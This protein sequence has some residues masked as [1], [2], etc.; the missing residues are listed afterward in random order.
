MAPK[1][2]KENEILD[3]KEPSLS[4]DDDL[5][6]N[7]GINFFNLGH[8]WN[9]H[10]S[11]EEIW[12]QLSDSK[13]DDWEILLRG[14]I[15]IAAGLHCLT[16]NKEKGSKGNLKKGW[17]KISLCPQNYFLGINF[18]R[19]KKEVEKCLNCPHCLL[20]YIIKRKKF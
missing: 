3:F 8:Y 7:Q 9:A 14:L 2:R 5:Q 4:N 12:I 17:S 10:D 13:K 20:G 1:K 11:W 6:F 19:M 15:Q 16:I 18:F